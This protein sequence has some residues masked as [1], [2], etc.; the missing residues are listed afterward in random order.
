MKLIL[1]EN[2]THNAGKKLWD[3]IRKQTQIKPHGCQAISKLSEHLKKPMHGISIAV[4]LATDHQELFEIVSMQDLLENIRVILILPDSDS[5]T[6]SLGLQLRTS[7]FSDVNGN[8]NDVAAVLNQ[9]VK[10]K[11]GSIYNA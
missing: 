10:K 7:F 11:S 2:G 8:F 4:L 1:Y 6:L 3:I 9:I 5:S